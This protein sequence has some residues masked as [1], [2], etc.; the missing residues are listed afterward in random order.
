MRPSILIVDDEVEILNSLERVLKRD[1]VTHTFSSA[2]KALSFFELNPTHLVLSDMRMPEM[3]GEDFLTQIRLLNPV[4]KCCV[5]TGYADIAAAEKA[6]NEAGI[7]AYF[8]KPWNNTELKEKLHQLALGLVSKQKKHKQI[9]ALRKNRKLAQINVDVMINV[10]TGMLDEHKL[11]QEELQV[12]KT[13]LRQF[14]III[15]T[16]SLSLWNDESGHEQRIASQAR[17]LAKLIGLDNR[18]CSDIFIAGLLY[19]IGSYNLDAELMNTPI[20]QLSGEQVREFQDS[21][22]VGAELISSVDLLKSSAL[23]VKHLYESV[24]GKG[25]PDRLVNEEIPIG[26]RILR[27]ITYYDAL[28]SGKVTGKKIPPERAK[29]LMDEY[30]FSTFDKKVVNSF[31]QLLG[32]PSNCCVERA[33]SVKELREDMVLAQDLYNENGI[34]VLAENTCLTKQVIE[35]LQVIEDNI[36][37]YLIVYIQ[38]QG[39]HHE[40]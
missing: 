34:K 6:I 35:Q 15:S 17:Q 1:F 5:M 27:V 16:I 36:G 33:C 20:E 23:I 21:V 13:S 8:S 22:Q 4:T 10:I 2:A 28:V 18:Q 25:E 11:T 31:Y 40:E 38:G 14:L 7:S 26:S 19:R 30:S 39:L 32:T 3:S 37:E 24:D 9:K 12:Y 29:K